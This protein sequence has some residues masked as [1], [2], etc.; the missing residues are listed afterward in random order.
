MLDKFF[1]SQDYVY[2]SPSF[3]PDLCDAIICVYI[4]LH[5]LHRALSFVESKK[6]K[7]VAPLWF[8]FFHVE[9]GDLVK[10]RK[11]SIQN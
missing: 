9:G 1:F 2:L 6:R 7:A 5:G 4:Y 10:E 8:A 11:Y 3:P